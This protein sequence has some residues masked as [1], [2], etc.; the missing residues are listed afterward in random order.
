M[1]TMEN[2]WR[3]RRLGH[4]NLFIGDYERAAEY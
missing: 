1:N 3:P 2:Y 4:A